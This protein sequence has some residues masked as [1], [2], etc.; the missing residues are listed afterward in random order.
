[1]ELISIAARALRDGQLVAFPTETVYGLGC[2]ALDE[3]A[4]AKV[5]QAKRRP[6]SDPLIVHM[7]G[8]AMVKIDWAIFTRCAFFHQFRQ[9]FNS[10]FSHN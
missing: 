5:F 6:S 9:R 10:I 2:N 4:I 3:Q 7:D 8:L 1:M